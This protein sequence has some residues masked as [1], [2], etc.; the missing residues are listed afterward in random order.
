MVISAPEARRDSAF[1]PRS[2]EESPARPAPPRVGERYGLHHRGRDRRSQRYS[3]QPTAVA[4]ASDVSSFHYLCPPQICTFPPRV[5]C[6][7]RSCGGYAAR[8]RKG[9]A[10][11]PAI[12]A[13]SYAPSGPSRNEG[14]SREGEARKRATPAVIAGRCSRLSC[15]GQVLSRPGLPQPSARPRTAPPTPA[16][17]PGRPAP[18]RASRGRVRTRSMNTSCFQ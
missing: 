9:S 1:M 2:T 17:A 8:T 7:R 12:P 3:H 6:A 13:P 5:G 16:H 18:S 14:L 11:V 4:S 10:G 15:G